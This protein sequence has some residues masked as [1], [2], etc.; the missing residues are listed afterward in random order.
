VIIY[1]ITNKRS[2]KQYVGQTV[3]TMSRRWYWHKLYARSGSTA[4]LHQAIMKYGE[5]SFTIEQLCVAASRQELSEKEAFYISQLKTVAPNGY[6]LTSGGESYS[7]SNELR[8][9]QAIACS[10]WHHTSSAKQKIS[11][12][13]RGRNVSIETCRRM[14]ASGKKTHCVRGHPLDEVNTYVSPIGA[15]CCLTC[16]YLAYV[17]RGRV[18]DLPERL[19]CY[20]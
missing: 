13:G 2:G 6:N 8:C 19:K 18:K 10:G 15:R 5:D 20:V 4:A 17:R 12:A 1:C 11:T 14:S 3:G 9:R 7:V 16:C